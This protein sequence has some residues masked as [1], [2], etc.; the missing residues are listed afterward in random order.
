[1]PRHTAEQAAQT[2]AAIVERAAERASVVGLEGLT[3]GSLAEDLGLSKAGVVGP[4]GSREELQLAAFRRAMAAFRERVW[5]PIAELPAGRE[6]LAA[7]C[8]R[9]IAELQA[10]AYPGGCF[11]TTASTEWDARSGAVHD[12]VAKWV[13][14]WLRTLSAEAEVAVRAGELP[15]DV[16]PDQFAFELNGLMMGLN[17]ALRL[18]GDPAAA[19]RARRSVGRLLVPP[20]KRSSAK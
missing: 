19:D 5:D 10:P 1:M 3:I 13:S 15:P 18:T 8:E 20:S 9:W 6:R 16:D 11:M 4:F 7:L 2:R 12:T 14:L 17:Q